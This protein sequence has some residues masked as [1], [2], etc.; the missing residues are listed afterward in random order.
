MIKRKDNSRFSNHSVVCPTA[1]ILFQAI[2][3]Q[4]RIEGGLAVS[5]K[6]AATLATCGHILQFLF[7]H[8]CTLRGF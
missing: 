7:S 5:S 6:G 8:I 4:R 1:P 3:R 2:N